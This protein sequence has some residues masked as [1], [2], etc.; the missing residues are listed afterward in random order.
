MRL[1]VLMCFMLAHHPT[2][3]AAEPHQTQ[4][5]KKIVVDKDHSQQQKALDK[6][7]DFYDVD[8][9]DQ[10]DRAGRTAVFSYSL[11]VSMMNPEQ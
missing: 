9:D 10:D 7:R 4:R 8:L 11:P 6:P 2:L 3:L 1:F 5:D